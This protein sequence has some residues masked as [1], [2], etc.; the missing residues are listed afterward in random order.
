MSAVVGVVGAGTMGT[1]IAQLAA[2]SGARTLLF[3]VSPDAVA[4]GLEQLDALAERGK[5]AADVR[6]R[7]EAVGSLGALAPA[8]AVVEAVAERLDVKRELFSA[9]EAVVAADALLATNTSS[10]SVTAMA[11]ALDH[12]ERLVGMHF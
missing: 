10:L 6:A 8:G 4:R 5:L 1:G 11:T 9:L 3:D 12:P 2:Q 7:V